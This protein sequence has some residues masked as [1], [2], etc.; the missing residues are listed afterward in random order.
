MEELLSKTG[1]VFV[2][3]EIGVLTGWAVGMSVSIGLWKFDPALTYPANAPGRD[4]SHECEIGDIAGDG[5]AGTDKC[6]AP[7]L[8]SAHNGGICANAGPTPD[9]RGLILV[10]AGDMAS[11]V[12]DIGEHHA[13]PT[14]NIV[15]KRH[16]V[17]Y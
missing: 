13:W 16:T 5:S 7:Y 14:K 3:Y 17:V 12:D 15:L 10:L 1:T 9:P 6:I 2:A 11:G 4:S 8:D